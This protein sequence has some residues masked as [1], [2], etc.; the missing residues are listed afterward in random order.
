MDLSSDKPNSMTENSSLVGSTGSV[1]TEWVF[2][3]VKA[4]HLI[5]SESQAIRVSKLA[6]NT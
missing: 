6:I 3:G 1:T 5:T 4:M 2:Q